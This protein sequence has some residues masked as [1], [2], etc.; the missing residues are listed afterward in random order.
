MATTVGVCDRQQG[1]VHDL[2]SLYFVLTMN[3]EQAIR[4]EH[5]K[6][7]C[8]KI[9]SYVGDDKKRFAQLMK[10]FFEGEYRVTQRAAWP[11]SNAV[12]KNPQ[13]ITPYVG[14][15]INK[16]ANP[17]EGDAVIRNIVRLLQSVE[18]PKRYH[19]KLMTLCFDFIQSNETAIAIKAFSLSILQNFAK[20]YPEIVPEVKTIIEERWDLETAAFR[21]R[22]RN[23]LKAQGTRHKVQEQ[24]SRHKAQVRSKI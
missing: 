10:L 4:D 8:N 6:A 22:A 1:V 13:L 24:G 19:G 5:S 9:V 18:I 23:F 3:L 20:Q 16:L 7:Q 14:K 21:S 15:L 12:Q 17:K 2:I 11:M